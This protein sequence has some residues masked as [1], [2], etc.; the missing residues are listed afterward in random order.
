MRRATFIL[1]LVLLTAPLRAADFDLHAAVRDAKPGQTLRIPAGRYDGTL[2]INKPL[3]LVADGQ[4]VIE[5]VGE[6]DVIRVTAPDVTLRG[7][8]VRR[9]GD[10]LDRENAGILARAPRATIENCVLEDVLFGIYL[11]RAPNSVVRNNRIGSK[12]LD[13]ARRG[14]VVKVWYSDHSIIENN[15]IADGRDLVMWYSKGLVV[16]GNNVT[17]CRYGIHFMFAGN[18]TVDDNRLIGNSVGIFLMYSEGLKLRRNVIARNRGP[19]GYGLGLKDVD[20]ADIT[21]NLI[22]DN[23]V[24]MHLDNSPSR[25]DVRHRHQR[26]VFAYNDIALGLMPNDQQNDFVDNT[27]FDNVEQISIIGGAHTARENQF[28]V[29]GRG[30]YWSDYRGYDLDGDGVGDVPH[31]AASLFENLVDRQPKLRLFLFSPAQQAIE[32]ASRA[33]PTVKPSIRAI[34]TAPRM[35]PLSSNIVPEPAGWSW[36]MASLGIGLLL[37][38]SIVAAVGLRPI[39][40]RSP[41]VTEPLT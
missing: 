16:R 38:G 29:D 34:D 41:L 39:G 35:K 22:V 31:R 33:F 12:P 10:N 21:D 30:N 40:G 5:G 11:Q 32:L 17:N 26:N 6:G 18:A 2:T 25:I 14:D 3:T 28:T 27:F 36:T 13:I 24:G 4:V 7:L 15:E 23:R 19:S 8:H 20:F 9:T 1:L 37:A